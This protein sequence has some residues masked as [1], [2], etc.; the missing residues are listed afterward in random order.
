M[1]LTRCPQCRTTFRITDE[2]LR[3][4]SGQVRCG[5]CK[6]AFDARA[7]LVK[8]PAAAGEGAEIARDADRPG[9]DSPIAGAAETDSAEAESASEAVGAIEDEAHSAQSVSATETSAVDTRSTAAPGTAEDDTFGDLS[10]ADVIEHVASGGDEDEDELTGVWAFGKSDANKESAD[11]SAAEAARTDTGISAE[12]IEA[13]L[14]GGEEAWPTATS[15]WELD[16]PAERPPASAWWRYGAL[17][18]VLLLATQV[19]HHFRADLAVNDA[20]GPWLQGAYGWF[21]VSIVPSWDLRQYRIMDWVAT[22]ER[23]ADGLG[24][25][26]I[27]ARI[28]NRG[29]RAQPYPHVHLQLKDRWERPVGSRVFRPD[30]YAADG[31]D[32]PRLMSAGD[33]AQARLEIVDPGSDAYGFELDVCLEA[34]GGALVC[35]ADALF[36]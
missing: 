3:K 35:A 27:T 26:D 13:V 19:V 30:E 24:S 31:A 28:Q 25:L 22:A 12:Q 21:G 5:R 10:L 33:T 8:A 15:A 34:E 16:R 7:A 32:V 11:A 9:A 17:L 29:P 20:I 36:R 1:R 23:G 4:A 18:A 2:A 6:T 14:E